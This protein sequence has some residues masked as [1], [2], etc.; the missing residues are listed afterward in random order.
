[1]PS[2]RP[3]KPAVMILPVMLREP[4]SD[5]CTLS[6]PLA[7]HPPLLLKSIRRNSLTHTSPDFC[8]LERL[9]IPIIMVFTSPNVGLP[10]I[11]TVLVGWLGSAMEY[12]WLK[13]EP[14]VARA[15]LRSFFNEVN[16]VRSMSSMFASGHTA[17]QSSTLYLL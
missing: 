8:S 6:A 3:P 14:P 11:L 12:I 9:R 2:S 1:M 10:K 15:L 5:N 4:T 13:D 16:S 7:A 17:R